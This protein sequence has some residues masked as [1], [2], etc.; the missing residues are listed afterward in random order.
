MRGRDLT[1]RVPRQEVRAHTPGLD[2]PEEGH[3]KSEERRLRVRRLVDPVPDVL[4][5][6]VKILVQLGADRVERRREH[7]KGLVQLTAH[8]G[9]LAP[10][11]GEQERRA[12]GGTRPAGD[13]AGRRLAAD[14][15]LQAA[16]QLLG[17]GADHGCPVLERRPRR[18]QREGDVGGDRSG[19]RV[20]AAQQPLGLLA[21][22][23]RGAARQHP[24]H[25][26][27]PSSRCRRLVGRLGGVGRRRLLQDDV[28]VGAA[29]AERRHSRATRLAGLR[30]VPLLGQ[31]LDRARRPVHVRGR[32]GDVQRLRQHAVAHRH[33][34]LHDPGGTGGGL[35]VAQVRLDRAQPERPVRRASLAVGREQRL[36]LDRVAQG[37]AGAVRLDHVDLVAGEGGPGERLLDHA[38]LRGAVGRGQA[39][40]RAVLVDRAAAYDGEDRVPVAPGVGELLDEQ[41]ADALAP[42]GAVRRVREGLAPAVGRQTA[43]AAELHEGAR[44]QHDGHTTGQRQ[45]RLTRAERL[46]GEVQGHQRG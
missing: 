31:Q 26:R 1:D 35:G 28:R 42:A 34:H 24:G 4:Q 25:Q 8:T 19:L 12:T 3:L 22:R 29:E 11:T 30:P 40:A 38:L 46:A 43:L 13:D 41:H 32:L 23:V 33:D 39:V 7:R 27:G 14:Q 17:L 45:R 21:E 44:R 20:Q 5:R 2:Q 16:P 9:P 18:G 15:R 36:G 6:A 37:G 10:L